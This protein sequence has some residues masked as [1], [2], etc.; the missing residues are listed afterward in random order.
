[1]EIKKREKNWSVIAAIR[2]EDFVRHPSPKTFTDCKAVTG[3]IKAWPVVRE[4]L[5]QY[6][7]KGELPWKQ[8]Q[9]PLPNSGLDVPQSKRNDLFP[10]VRELIDLAILEKK[11]E[12][13]L[14]WYDQLHPK[15]YGW[16]GV[17]LDA[18]AKAILSHAPERA[19]A[20][21]KDK[22]ERLI[23][24]VKPKAYKEAGIY[25]RKAADVMAKENKLKEWDR[26]IQR[27]REHHARKIRLLEVLDSLENKSIIKKMR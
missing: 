27:L 13:V 12:R 18:I 26:Y 3:R 8:N 4:S 2:A 23:A 21:W 11:P 1:L 17:N 15:K 6:L 20:I 22:A 9:W 16:Y 5:L 10:M 7:E 14:H 25:L 19:V 24:Q